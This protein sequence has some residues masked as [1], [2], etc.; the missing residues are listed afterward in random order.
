MSSRREKGT[1]NV[2]QRENGSWVGRVDIGRK[3]DGSRK[4]KYFS[5]KTEAQVRKKIREY[6]KLS[7]NYEP[8]KITVE[9]YA[10]AWLKRYKANTIRGS[11]YDRLENALSERLVCGECGTLYR[12]CTWAKKE[13]SEWYGVV[14]ATWIM[15]Q[16]TATTRQAWRKSRCSELF[17][18]PSIR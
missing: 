17:W 16:N 8:E 5:G 9:E 15:E 18:R 14:S 10:W 3:S 7:N 4:I 12:R 11:S 2:Y 6:N 13:R 1:G